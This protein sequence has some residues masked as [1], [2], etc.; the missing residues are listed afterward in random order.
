M[1]RPVAW[2]GLMLGLIGLVMLLA[3]DR[4]AKKDRLAASGADTRLL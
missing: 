1:L 4:Q 2:E 3:A